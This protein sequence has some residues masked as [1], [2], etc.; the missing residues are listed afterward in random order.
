MRDDKGRVDIARASATCTL[1][2]D[3]K[4]VLIILYVCPH[5]PIN[6]FGSHRRRSVLSRLTKK[7]MPKYADV[8]YCMLTYADVC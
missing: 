5:T 7:R 2:V 3:K 6:V 8:C 1:E 4:V